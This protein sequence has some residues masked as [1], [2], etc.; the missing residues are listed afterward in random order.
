[1]PPRKKSVPAAEQ[2]SSTSEDNWIDQDRLGPYLYEWNEAGTWGF[3]DECRFT[4]TLQE[5][6]FL[7]RHDRKVGTVTSGRCV[8]SGSRPGDQVLPE[9]GTQLGRTHSEREDR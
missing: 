7:G 2:S 3:C 6:G 1:M 8:G 5:D 9:M 4:V